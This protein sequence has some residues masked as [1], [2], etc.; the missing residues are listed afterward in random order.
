MRLAPMQQCATLLFCLLETQQVWKGSYW[1]QGL[2]GCV[3]G[4]SG[5]KDRYLHEVICLEVGDCDQGEDKPELLVLW[6]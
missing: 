6:L 4:L 2:F 3:W 5:H 1:G